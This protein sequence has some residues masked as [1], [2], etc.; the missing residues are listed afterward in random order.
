IGN[1]SFE[2]LRDVK[3]ALSRFVDVQM[4]TGD[5]VAIVRLEQRGILQQFTSD[6]RLLHLAI[7]GVR[8]NPLTGSTVSAIPQPGS[9]GPTTDA[10]AAQATAEADDFF[11]DTVGNNRIQQLNL[12]VRGLETLP[13]RKSVILFSDGFQLFGKGQDNRRTMEEVQRLT[14]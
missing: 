9:S 7:N 6:K 10:E 11:E 4:Q 13:G 3:K 8:W 5:L 14:D 12:V 2:G 1:V